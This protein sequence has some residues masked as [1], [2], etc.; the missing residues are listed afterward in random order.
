MNRS[1]EE[2]ERARREREGEREEREGG[3][4]GKECFQLSNHIT[5]QELDKFKCSHVVDTGG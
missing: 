3:R 1:R 2:R 5:L 4:E